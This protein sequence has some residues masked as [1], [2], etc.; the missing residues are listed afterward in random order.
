M[1]LARELGYPTM[2]SSIRQ[3]IM[4]GAW[5][6]R[7][8]VKQA[9]IERRHATKI[10]LLRLDMLAICSETT[11][12]APSLWAIAKLSIPQAILGDFVRRRLCAIGKP[13]LMPSKESHADGS[14]EIPDELASSPR[15]ACRATQCQN[16]Y[17][18]NSCHRRK[19]GDPG[20]LAQCH[21]HG[22]AD[23]LRSSISWN[24]RVSRLDS[25]TLEDS[26]FLVA[27]YNAKNRQVM[28]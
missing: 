28:R 24:A 16:W 2:P 15:T 14:I 3:L 8:V 13:K 26:S 19:P 18:W 5:P 1:N 21:R 9:K 22:V 17:C 12:S 23:K 7:S 10:A 11:R 25:L 20:R 27:L 6:K 4:R